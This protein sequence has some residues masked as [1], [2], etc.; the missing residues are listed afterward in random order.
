MVGRGG[1]RLALDFAGMVGSGMTV[2][3]LNSMEDAL[4][5]ITFAVTV[6]SRT[7]DTLAGGAGNH[8]L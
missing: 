1:P 3:L 4:H 8:Q 6:A 2:V 7:Y 5:F